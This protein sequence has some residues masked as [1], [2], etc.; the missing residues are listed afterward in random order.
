MRETIL[1]LPVT[2]TTTGNSL[3]CLLKFR[4]LLTLMEM[5]A[6]VIYPSMCAAALA[7][8]T[9]AHG[10]TFLFLDVLLRE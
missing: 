7:P 6:I 10:V 5:F 3:S 8:E 9:S 4:E 2:T 1:V